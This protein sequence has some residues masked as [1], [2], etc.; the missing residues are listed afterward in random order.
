[1]TEETIMTD[2][3]V[4]IKNSRFISNFRK[5]NPEESLNLVC[6]V[7]TQFTVQCFIDCLKSIGNEFVTPEGNFDDLFEKYLTIHEVKPILYVSIYLD[8]DVLLKGQSLVSINECLK[9]L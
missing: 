3:E 4:L 1:M 5:Y 9:S 6:P 2:S 7:T 8:S